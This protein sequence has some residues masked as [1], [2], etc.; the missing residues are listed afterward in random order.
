M[1]SEA[2][3]LAMLGARDQIAIVCE[4]GA[5]YE[6]SKYCDVAQS[7]CDGTGDVHITILPCLHNELPGK[8]SS[9]AL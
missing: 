8:G 5:Q 4:A 3:L 7:A 2:A 1:R 9:E 6:T